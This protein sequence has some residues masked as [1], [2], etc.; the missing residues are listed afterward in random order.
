MVY[1]NP[2]ARKAFRA[3]LERFYDIAAPVNQSGR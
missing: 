2:Q 1:L 3:D